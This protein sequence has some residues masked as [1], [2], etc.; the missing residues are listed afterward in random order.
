[1]HKHFK[2]SFH[3]SKFHYTWTHIAWITHMLHHI[4]VSK[5]CWLNI[6]LSL[7]RQIAVFRPLG[8]LGIIKCPQIKHL[9]VTPKLRGFHV[10]VKMSSTF[11]WVGAAYANRKMG[12]STCQVQGQKTSLDKP[13][14]MYYPKPLT[15]VWS[16][17]SQ[18]SRINPRASWSKTPIWMNEHAKA[19]PR[20]VSIRFNK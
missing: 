3:S 7:N 17:P 15:L 1:M 9:I 12:G 6:Q 2:T 20:A 11:M 16:R 14:L 5:K 13:N 8:L 10:S 18:I 19:D 4:K